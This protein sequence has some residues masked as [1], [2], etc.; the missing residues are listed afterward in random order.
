MAKE[1]QKL[2]LQKTSSEE[3]VFDKIKNIKIL[4]MPCLEKIY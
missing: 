1:G 4:T 3:D 2:T